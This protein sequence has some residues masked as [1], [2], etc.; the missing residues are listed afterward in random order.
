MDGFLVGSHDGPFEGL[1]VGN[2][3]VGLA[4]GEV[5]G[6]LIGEFDGR[7]LGEADGGS[8]GAFDGLVVYILGRDI[9]GLTVGDNVRFEQDPTIF[10]LR[11]G[12]RPYDLHETVMH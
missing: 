8:E 7:S 5:D 6:C 12:S 9:E 4:K 1:I 3:L 11:P 10:H 2:A